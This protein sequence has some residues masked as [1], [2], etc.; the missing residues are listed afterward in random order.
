M[1][2]SVTTAPAPASTDIPTYNQVPETSYECMFSFL[3]EQ[4][5]S[6]IGRKRLLIDLSYTVEWADLATLDLSLFDQPG[7]KEQLATKLYD[8]IQKIG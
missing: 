4:F 6:S 8:A 1:A 2:A 7:G 5:H 3:C